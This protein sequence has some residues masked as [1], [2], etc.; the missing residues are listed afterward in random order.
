MRNARNSV[1]LPTS[2]LDFISFM[3]SILDEEIEVPLHSSEEFSVAKEGKLF[4][5]FDFSTTGDILLLSDAMQVSLQLI[6]LIPNMIY[7]NKI[8]F[9]G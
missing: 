2:V 3:L 1:S 7:L 8:C 4:G 5:R 6:S 9:D